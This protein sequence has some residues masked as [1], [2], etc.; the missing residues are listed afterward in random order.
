[1]EVSDVVAAFTFCFM[2]VSAGSREKSSL[3]LIVFSLFL[4]LLMGCT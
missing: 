1:M 4:P 3:P 2:S